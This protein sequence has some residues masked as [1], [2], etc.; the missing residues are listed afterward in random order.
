MACFYQYPPQPPGA[1]LGDMTI[2]GSATRGMDTGSKT[3][4]ADKMP[5][6]GETLYITYLAEYE[7]SGV[8]SNTWHTH[9]D[10]SLVV[11]FR[12]LVDLIGYL[13]EHSHELLSHLQIAIYSLSV[14]W[15][16]L[17]LPKEL[18]AFLPKGIRVWQ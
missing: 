3:S 10:L 8:A 16:E 11:Q 18:K 9:E 13:L 4:V 6:T 7:Q 1:L 14:A 2:V 12:S 5:L 15:T 17:Y